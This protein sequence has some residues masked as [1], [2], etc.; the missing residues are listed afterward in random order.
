[1]LIN[2]DP[3]L[4]ALNFSLPVLFGEK[5]TAAQVRVALVRR[6]VEV[7]PDVKRLAL[8]SVRLGRL[9]LH[10]YNKINIIKQFV[11]RD[12]NVYEQITQ[13]KQCVVVFSL[14]LINGKLIAIYAAPI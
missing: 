2:V 3:L 8:C 6:P 10:K 5:H 4:L 11:K 12:K 7:F 1:M 9:F 13:I 14:K